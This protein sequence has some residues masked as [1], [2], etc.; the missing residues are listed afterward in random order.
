MEMR[1]AIGRSPPTIQLCLR[2]C[3][4]AADPGAHHAT[5]SAR[6]EYVHSASKRR[7]DLHPPLASIF[8]EARVL[9]VCRYA[10]VPV[11][12]GIMGLL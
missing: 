8:R 5:N 1:S 12:Q 3:A 4:L 10:K 2:P 11:L 6:A 9:G 7:N